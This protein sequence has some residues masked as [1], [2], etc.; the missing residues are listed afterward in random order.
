MMYYKDSIDEKDSQKIKD[1][2]QIL[3]DALDKKEDLSSIYQ[4]FEELT[5]IVEDS[6][7]VER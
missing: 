7:F 1:Q 3:K 6:L 5:E 4:R 2:L